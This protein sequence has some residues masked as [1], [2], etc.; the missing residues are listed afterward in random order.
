MPFYE[1][2]CKDCGK[3]FEVKLPMSKA[4]EKQIC[5]GCKSSNTLRIFS[6]VSVMNS[7]ASDSGNY[8][9]CPT[10]TCGLQ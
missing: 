2:K 10:G 7:S 4:G 3:E 8:P 6:T 1:F 9:S 5:P